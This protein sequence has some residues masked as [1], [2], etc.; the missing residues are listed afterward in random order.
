MTKDRPAKGTGYKSYEEGYQGKEGTDDRIRLWKE[1]FRENQGGHGT[2][3]EK[4]V[5]FNCRSKHAGE[6][7]TRHLS[8]YI[9]LCVSCHENL[10]CDS[11]TMNIMTSNHDTWEMLSA[12]KGQLYVMNR[13]K[14]NGIGTRK[15]IRTPFLAALNW[16]RMLLIAG[17]TTKNLLRN[18]K[19][20]A[21]R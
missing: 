10:H 3:E 15:L 20:L 5:P 6:D 21:V 1:D 8:P 18:V 2:V 16:S 12:P 4:V 17:L 9:L 13:E 7:N 14:M 11:E 19:R